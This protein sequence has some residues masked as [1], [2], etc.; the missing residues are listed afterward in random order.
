MRVRPGAYRFLPDSK[1]IVY[2][3]TNAWL[4]FRMLDL[5][6]KKDRDLTRF[7]NRGEVRTFDV[8]PDGKFVVFDR[9]TPNSDIILI[10]LPKPGAGAPGPAS[11]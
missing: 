4:D 11:R 7:T 2:L 3:R 6:T 8:T 9:A 10:D 5:V 1:R